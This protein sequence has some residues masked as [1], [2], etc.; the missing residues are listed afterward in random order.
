MIVGENDL[1]P[2]FR[3]CFI[4]THLDPFGAL[5][6][7]DLVYAIVRG[8][9]ATSRQTPSLPPALNE[10]VSLE[11]GVRKAFVHGLR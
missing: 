10:V 1:N 8:A 9:V 6:V 5:A 11:D 2:N 4:Q 3:G 7:A